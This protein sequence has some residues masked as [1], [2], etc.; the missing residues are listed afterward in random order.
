MKYKF[1]H[2]LDY[3]I[4]IIFGQPDPPAALLPGKNPMNKE[5]VGVWMMWLA[6][7]LIFHW[8][9]WYGMCSTAS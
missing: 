5:S 1:I 8:S 3:A 2:S 6:V 4:N 7:L 9:V